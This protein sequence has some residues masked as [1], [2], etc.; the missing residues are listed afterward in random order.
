[1]NW[2]HP[3]LAEVSSADQ[4]RINL[5]NPTDDY[6]QKRTLESLF[7]N[8]EEQRKRLHESLAVGDG[9]ARLP[10]NLLAKAAL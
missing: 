8:D 1:M 9:I 6:K 4:T 10:R 3:E 2:P 7:E 5:L